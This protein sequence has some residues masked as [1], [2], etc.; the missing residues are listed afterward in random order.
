MIC[1]GRSGES[2]G[3]GRGSSAQA[4]CRRS[5]RD[6]IFYLASGA[7]VALTFGRLLLRTAW[8][9]WLCAAAYFSAPLLDTVIYRPAPDISEN[10]CA[11]CAVLAWWAMMNDELAAPGVAGRDRGRP[12]DRDRLLQSRDRRLHRTDP[13]AHDA[14]VLSA[15][16]EV[17]ARPGGRLGL[18]FLTECAVY[19][20]VCGDWL[21][22]LHANLGAG[23]AKDVEVTPIWKLP[24][25]FINVLFHGNRLAPISTILAIIGTWA[26][27]RK[28]GVPGR[29]L[30][31]WFY[32]MY[33]IY[34]C[35][36]QSL[37]PVLPLIGS[38]ARYMSAL[39]LPHSL[40]A[41]SG[42]CRSGRSSAGSFRR[43]RRG[44][45][46]GARSST[47]RSSSALRVLHVAVLRSRLHEGLAR[48]MNQLPDGTK[49]FTHHL[50]H[51]TAFLAD[52]KAARRFAWTDRRQILVSRPDLEAEAAACDEF[53]YLRKKVWLVDARKPSAIR[54]WTSRSLAR[55]SRRR[56][57]TGNWARSS[58][59]GRDG[60]G[61]VLAPAAHRSAAARPHGAVT[62]IRRVDPGA[63]PGMECDRP[64]EAD[65]GEVGHPGIPPRK[66]AVNP[67]GGRFR[68]R[69]AAQRPLCLRREAGAPVGDRAQADLL[70]HRR[71]RFFRDQNPAERRALRHRIQVRQERHQCAA[72]GLRAVYDDAP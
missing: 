25:R 70:P 24:F 54:R 57:A 11:G 46:P 38:T 45:T 69:R 27:W 36:V 64:E 60:R 7:A 21:H 48:Y 50:M 63:S 53:W 72:T 33:L 18:F 19:Q 8:G 20:Y 43:S 35:S 56:N 16:L 37:H 68:Q 15:P 12:G 65:L 6:P 14:D 42:S 29:L 58:R 67:H 51:D 9:G 59:R 39:A 3:S 1:A 47:P 40:L 41:A 30:V 23:S 22:S 13:R 17:A 31:V 62:G 55:T 61:D 34:S 5:T 10:V 52:V 2:A 32:A 44:C 4:G 26:A 28:H 49:I 71:V 66:N